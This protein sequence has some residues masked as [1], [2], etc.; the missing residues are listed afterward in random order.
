M[1]SMPLVLA[2]FVGVL[3]QGL[4]G[5]GGPVSGYRPYGANVPTFTMTAMSVDWSTD[6]RT[7]RGMNGTRIKYDCPAMGGA[8]VGS[9]YG[10]D[11][12]TDDSPVCGSGFFSG[13]INAS[14]GPVVIEIRAGAAGY[15]A[16]TANGVTTNSYGAY[17]GSYIVL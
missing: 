16:G 9:V 13:R 11:L 4:M 1:R 14:G 17:E 2:A 5:C 6:A 12:F 15:T 3:A 7:F 10:S 8:S